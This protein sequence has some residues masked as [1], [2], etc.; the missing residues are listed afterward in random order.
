MGI[1]CIPN[2]RDNFLGMAGMHGSYAANMAIMECDLLIAVGMRFDDRV[3]GVVN[4]FAPRA[5]I[6]H[7]DVDAAEI[8][9]NVPA[10]YRVLGDLR[11]SLPVFRQKLGHVALLFP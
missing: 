5:K 2:D 11:W 9:K 7:F 8:N 10:D 3:T 1:G 6:V 4:E